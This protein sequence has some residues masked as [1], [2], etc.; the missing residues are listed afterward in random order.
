[1][2]EVAYLSGPNNDKNCSAG[3]HNIRLL[4]RGLQRDIGLGL[5]WL[6]KRIGL[7]EIKADGQ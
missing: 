2:F 7:C 4:S 1:M 3:L 6:K 5:G